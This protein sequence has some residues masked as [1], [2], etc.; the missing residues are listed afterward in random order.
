M[1]QKNVLLSLSIIFMFM[2]LYEAIDGKISGTLP[3]NTCHSLIVLSILL[4][5]YMIWLLLKK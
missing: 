5:P 4:I 2:L 1:N 3:V